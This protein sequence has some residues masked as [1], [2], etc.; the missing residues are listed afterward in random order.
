VRGR[1]HVIGALAGLAGCAA[2]GSSGY[3]QADQLYGYAPGFPQPGE[4][5][6]YAPSY[7]PYGYAPEY[8]QPAPSPGLRFPYFDGGGDRHH[9]REEWHEHH[10][11]AGERLGSFERGEGHH[12]G[13]KAPPAA[14]NVPPPA[15][16]MPPPNFR[17]A[18]AP[19]SA[20]AGNARALGAL[21]FRPNPHP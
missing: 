7:S 13:F 10:D 12:N 1:L 17:P 19:P 4:Y 3:S 8:Y 9:A 20:A 21:G 5:Y 11:R 18:P 15:G 16:R 2:N 14:A 6:G